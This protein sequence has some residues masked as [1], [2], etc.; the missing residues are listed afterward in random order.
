MLI[1]QIYKLITK[2][3]MLNFVCYNIVNACLIVLFMAIFINFLKFNKRRERKKEKKSIVET[4]TMILFFILFC[5]VIRT[6][7]GRLSFENLMLNNALTV[8]GTTFIF[9][10]TIINLLG[11]LK[12]G[13]N[14][15]NQ[16]I[17]YSNHS[18]VK[19]GAYKYVRHPLYASIILMFLGGA[20]MYK[21]WM[22]LMLTVIIFIPFMN[23]R[24]KQEEVLLRGIFAE[25]IEYEKNVGRF[26]PKWRRKNGQV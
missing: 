25:Y 8:I 9:F 4:G 20:I 7:Y 12:L 17:I 2:M 6:G 10:G 1:E 23:Y 11:R 18:L 22:G 24:A 14:W 26:S 13:N 15:G 5:F 21:D 16:I 19:N 3:G